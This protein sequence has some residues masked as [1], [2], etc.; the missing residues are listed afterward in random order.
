MGGHMGIDTVVNAYFILLLVGAIIS[1]L[2]GLGLMKKIRSLGKGYFALVTLSLIILI[3]LV[4][5]FQ[6][7]SAK[8]SIGTIP[9]LFDQAIVIIFYPFYLIITWFLL[10]KIKKKS[11]LS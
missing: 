9:W 1:F 3:A 7:A 4:L 2:V 6:L 11:V 5:W 10:K 8:L